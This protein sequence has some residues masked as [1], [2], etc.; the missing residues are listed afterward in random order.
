MDLTKLCAKDLM[1]N[2]VKF[3]TEA[4]PVLKAASLMRDWGVSSLVVERKNDNDA[5]GIITRKDIVEA[6][7]SM[8]YGDIPMTDLPD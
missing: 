6:L 2:D 1:Q 8:M 4:T 5:L 7:M 3:V